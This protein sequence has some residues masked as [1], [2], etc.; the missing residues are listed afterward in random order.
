MKQ[1]SRMSYKDIAMWVMVGI[2]LILIATPF[3]QVLKE[4]S[5]LW[6]KFIIII[7]LVAIIYII[8]KQLRE[9]KEDKVV[10]K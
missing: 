10:I 5:P 2:F 7:T 9:R 6:V 4:D 3:Y 1:S 8:K